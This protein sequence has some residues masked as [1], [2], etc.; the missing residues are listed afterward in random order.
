MPLGNR[1][2]RTVEE[3]SFEK[4][5][6]MCTGEGKLPQHHIHGGLLA[7]SDSISF[8]LMGIKKRGW[9]KGSKC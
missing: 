1:V 2:N 5:Q 6:V 4:R 8:I 3:F 7:L 9:G